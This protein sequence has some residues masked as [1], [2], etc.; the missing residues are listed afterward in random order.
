VPHRANQTSFRAGHAGGPGRPRGSRSKLN[1]LALSLLTVDFVEHGAALIAEVRKRKPESYLLGVLSLLPKQ[2]VV[3][4]HDPFADIS[5][6]ELQA[7]QDHLAAVRAKLVCQIEAH[8]GNGAATI[9][10]NKPITRS[11]GSCA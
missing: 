2:S 11:A 9:D 5:D 10:E 8:A 4:R 7:L 1:E 6:S 3:E